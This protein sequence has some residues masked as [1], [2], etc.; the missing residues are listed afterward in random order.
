MTFTLNPKQFE[1]LVASLDNLS[2]AITNLGQDSEGEVAQIQELTAKLKQ[3][4][5]ALA[6]AENSA[7][8]PKE[9]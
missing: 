8:A 6:N 7:A 4:Q 9:T 5:D 3:S 2:T 1:R